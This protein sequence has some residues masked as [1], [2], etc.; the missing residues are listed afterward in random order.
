VLKGIEH[1]V[2]AH[3]LTPT[4]DRP[5]APIAKGFRG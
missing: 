2:L 4:A 5:F 1:P 3:V